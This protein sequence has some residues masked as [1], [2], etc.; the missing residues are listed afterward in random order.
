MQDSN[1]VKVCF[2]FVLFQNGTIQFSGIESSPSVV[3]HCEPG[4]IVDDEACSKFVE[5]ITCM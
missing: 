5:Y 4:Y 3:P 2:R 1:L